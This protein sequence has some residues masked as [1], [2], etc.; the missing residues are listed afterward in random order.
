MIICTPGVYELLVVIIMALGV[1]MMLCIR[2]IET[3]EERINQLKS[4]QIPTP[5][6]DEQDEQAPSP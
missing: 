3:Q 2:T 4:A 1:G 6:F 5:C